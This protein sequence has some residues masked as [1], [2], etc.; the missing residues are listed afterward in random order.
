MSRMP[1]TG[2]STSKPIAVAGSRASI[3]AKLSRGI[4]D[5]AIWSG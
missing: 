2:P 1:D 5:M 3:K 4:R